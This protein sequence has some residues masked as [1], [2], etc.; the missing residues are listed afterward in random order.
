MRDELGTDALPRVGHHDA[1]EPAVQR[2]AHADGAALIRE[3][4]RVRQQIPDHLPQTIRIAF[5]QTLTRLET[6]L[7]F[8]AFHVCRR[9]QRIERGFN[10]RR[11]IE[12]MKIETKIAGDDSRHVEQIVNEPRLRTRVAL[13]RLDRA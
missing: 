8:Y 5:D 7:E 9:S 13:D 6:R 2:D 12:R 11:E 10:N 4:E 1:H 3:F